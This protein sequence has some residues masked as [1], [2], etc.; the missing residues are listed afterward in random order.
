MASIVKRGDYQFQATVRRKGYPRQCKTFE[1]EKDAKDWAKVI[2]SEMIRRV[3]IDRSELER[4]TLGEL[5][6][7]YQGQVTITKIGERQERSRIKRWLAHPLSHRTLA[8]LRA[9]DFSQYRDARLKDVGPNTVRLELSLIS[10]VFDHARKDWGM[11]VKNLIADITLPK[12]P[13]GRKRRLLGD[14]EEALL[15]AASEARAH[16]LQLCAAIELAIETGLREGRLAALRWDQVD[17]TN[18]VIWVQTKGE[19]HKQERAA[20]PLTV[21]AEE[22]LRSLPKD[23]GGSVFGGA[24]PTAQALGS[25]FRRARDRAGLENL[26]FHDLRHEAAS[27]L[28]P[29]VQAP[30]LAKLMTWKTLQM[31]M[32]YYNP[33]PEELVEAVRRSAG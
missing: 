19:K 10:A 13:P 6:E 18:L 11:P 28:A 12:L 3:F 8:S 29:R 26:T 1:S 9:V 27:R 32:R 25:A 7:R 30:T 14:E 15:K 16:P 23:N 21:R 4:T 17:F 22:I 33:K 2:E 24:F 31:A 20:V 5:L